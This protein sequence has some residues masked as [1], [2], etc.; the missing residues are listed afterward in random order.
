MQG[1]KERTKQF[2]R[3]NTRAVGQGQADEYALVVI[4]S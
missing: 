2:G 4:D 3:D 1:A